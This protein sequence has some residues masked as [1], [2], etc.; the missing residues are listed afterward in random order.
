MPCDGDYQ[1][2]TTV[3]DPILH[4]Y[5]ITQTNALSKSTNTAYLTSLGVPYSGDRRE[6]FFGVNNLYRLD[7]LGRTLAR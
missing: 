5:P 2:T 7:G 3:Y 6:S 4:T 1:S